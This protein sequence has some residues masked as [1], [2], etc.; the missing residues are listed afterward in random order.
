MLAMNN[1]EV[2]PAIEETICTMKTARIQENILFIGCIETKQGL[3]QIG[4]KLKVAFHWNIETELL[5]ERM[6]A[7]A[8]PFE[9]LDLLEMIRCYEFIG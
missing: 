1:V 5:L 4:E 3:L 2:T 7:A 8:T 9:I 6:K